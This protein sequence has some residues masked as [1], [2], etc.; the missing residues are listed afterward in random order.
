[1]TA[2]KQCADC[3]RVAFATFQGRYYCTRCLVAVVE[4]ERE[5]REQRE[6]ER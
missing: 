4:E 3:G 6:T 5:R 1:M 2:D